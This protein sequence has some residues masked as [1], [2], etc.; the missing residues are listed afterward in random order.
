MK[1]ASAIVMIVL[2]LVVLEGPRAAT[3]Q[4]TEKQ[5]RI[6]L[7]R[8]WPE[9]PYIA[10][11][12]REAFREVGYT[13]N[14][15]AVLEFRW[16][17]GNV[18]RAVAHAR[19]LVDMKV[20][21]LVVYA[22]PAIKPAQDATKTIPI[23]MLS[24]DPV[25]VGVV[26]TLARPG[27]NVTGVS[28]NSVALSGKRL[29]LIRAILPRA[30][31][32]AYLASSVDPNG[33]RF[34]EQTRVDAPKVG[35]QAQAVFVRG[36]NEF[37]GAF[38]TILNERPDALIVQPLFAQDPETVRQ[39]VD[40]ATKHKLPTIS[41]PEPFAE[42]GG[43]IAYGANRAHLHRLVAIYVDRILKGAKPADLPVQDPTKFDLVINL[44]TAKAIGLEISPS[45]VLRADRVLR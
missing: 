34:V 9:T 42:W 45:V 4:P 32:V 30:T 38:A 2:V 24:A 22:T 36:A 14:R 44:K 1:R 8:W 6:G 19:E 25:G 10:E 5:P 15:S 26:A 37:D 7:L 3:S 11:L 21:V 28:T 33:K 35:L 41:D 27:G 18:D 29:D 40:F 43:L 17:N 16:A 20:D 13:H 39:I 31:R 23:V 12:V